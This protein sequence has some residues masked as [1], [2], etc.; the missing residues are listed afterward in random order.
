MCE[1]EKWGG[2]K[3]PTAHSVS[4]ACKLKLI[5]WFDS[6]QCIL[7]RKDRKNLP[8]SCADHLHRQKLTAAECYPFITTPSLFSFDYW[9]TYWYWGHLLHYLS[10][11]TCLH[12]QRTGKENHRFAFSSAAAWTRR[13]SLG[14][15]GAHISS[16]LLH[17]IYFVWPDI[18]MSH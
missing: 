11:W 4:T 18:I 2:R 5:V 9:V 1:I 13:Q 3:Y 14:A 6:F 17:R 10:L 16:A 15:Q 8:L 12:P 7:I